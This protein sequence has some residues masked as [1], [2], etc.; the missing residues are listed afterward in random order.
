M[1][2]ALLSFLEYRN[3]KGR[4]RTIAA[5]EAW[6]EGK[7]LL[8]SWLC[9]TNQGKNSLPSVSFMYLIL[10]KVNL[11]TSQPNIAAKTVQNITQAIF[12]WISVNPFFAIYL[13]SRTLPAVQ[14][15]YE[16]IAGTNKAGKYEYLQ[17][18]EPIKK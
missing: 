13:F 5:R 14:A 8:N 10:P 3:N 17:V 2:S 7:E 9:T 11:M 6:P 16:T 15:T 18:N 1:L 12:T 4:T